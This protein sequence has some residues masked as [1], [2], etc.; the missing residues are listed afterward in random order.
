MARSRYSHFNKIIK[1]PGTSFQSPA[2]NQKHVR[3][4]YYTSI[5]PN[6]IFIVLK[7]KCKLHY[8]AMPMMT[9]QSLKSVNFTKTRKSKYLENGTFFLQIKNS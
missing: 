1:G 2:L 7:N 4:V 9:S 8:V 5:W 6:F 3:N